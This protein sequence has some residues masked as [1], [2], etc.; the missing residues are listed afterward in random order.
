M[1]RKKVDFFLRLVWPPLLTSFITCTIWPDLPF[2][3]FATAAD[4]DEV[5]DLEEV[6]EFEE[7]PDEVEDW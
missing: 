3:L 1:E 6:E 2:P 7:I 4:T 5:D